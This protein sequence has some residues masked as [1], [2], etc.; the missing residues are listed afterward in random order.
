MQLGKKLR[1]GDNNIPSYE[2]II[3]KPNCICLFKTFFW[4]FR[5]GGRAGVEPLKPS[6]THSWLGLTES[7]SRRGTQGYVFVYEH[8][9]E[10]QC[11][12][13]QT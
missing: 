8:L 7:N 4:N 9:Y 3:I 5:G 2:I 10:P 13:V 6:Y 1:N 12:N 11:N